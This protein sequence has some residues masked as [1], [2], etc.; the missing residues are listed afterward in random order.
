M[1][2]VEVPG[3]QRPFL[4]TSKLPDTS[5]REAKGLD[6]PCLLLRAVKTTQ[7]SLLTTSSYHSVPA[8][9]HPDLQP[10]LLCRAGMG[11]IKTPVTVDCTLHH[12]GLSHLE[13]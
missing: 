9:P 6:V 5:R 10:L 13:P 4:W 11:H 3:I 8:R 12:M 1:H 7:C 2:D